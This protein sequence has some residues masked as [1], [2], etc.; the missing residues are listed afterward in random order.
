MLGEDLRRIYDAIVYRAT[1]VP[2]KTVA[3]GA[4]CALSIAALLA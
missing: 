3:G 1:M 2:R 4:N